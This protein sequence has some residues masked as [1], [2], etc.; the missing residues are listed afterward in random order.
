VA[1]GEQL[2]V[3]WLETRNPVADFDYDPRQIAA[4]RCWQIEFEERLEGALCDH[5]INRIQA[6]RMDLNEDFIR[7]W[8]W[9]RNVSKRHVITLG[10]SGE[11]ER[12]HVVSSWWTGRFST[13][14][15]VLT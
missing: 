4:E 8:R 11:C 2:R 12:S 3:T 14:L 10:I 9:S 7:F 6:D 15:R 1:R 5:E 13:V